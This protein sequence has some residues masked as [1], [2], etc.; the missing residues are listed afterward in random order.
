MTYG[1]GDVYE[2]NFED[3]EE[4]G[5]GKM[6]YVRGEVYDGEWKNGMREGHC[7]YRFADGTIYEEGL[8]L[9][10]EGGAAR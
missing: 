3:N 1:N 6:T 5:H 10:I 9:V 7:T 4:N 2:G 8:G